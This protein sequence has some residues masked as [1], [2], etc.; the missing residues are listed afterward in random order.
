MI[1]DK[2]DTDTSRRGFLSAVAATAAA[3][4]LPGVGSADE[5]EAREALF[6]GHDDQAFSR[7]RMSVNFAVGL[8][9]RTAATISFGEDPNTVD[10]YVEE[11]TAEFENHRA[12]WLTFVN[13]R[14]LGDEDHQSL[15]LTFEYEGE[16]AKRYVLATF[17]EESDEYTDVEVVEEYDDDAD[18]RATLGDYP[19][20]NAAD[21]LAI[22]HDEYIV[23]G[24][25][26]DRSHISR[27]AGR[28]VRGEDHV[29]ASFIG[30]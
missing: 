18:V 2:S 23:P 13:T 30:D 5:Q 21:E 10:D 22:L 4:V 26:I 19:T 15:A 25:D 1:R 3:T 12:E 29:T 11:A 24:V 9:E 17:D 8:M 28:Y 7:T 16:V 14:G 27:L 6:T 20:S